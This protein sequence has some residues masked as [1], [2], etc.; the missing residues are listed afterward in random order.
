MVTEMSSLKAARTGLKRVVSGASVFLR[1]RKMSGKESTM[2]KKVVSSLIVII[3][4]A[5]VLA[6]VENAGAKCVYKEYMKKLERN[7]SVPYINGYA[8]KNYKNMVAGGIKYYFWKTNWK[9][10]KKS[11]S[12]E[13]FKYYKITNIGGDKKPELIMSKTKYAQGNGRVLICKYIKGKVRP[14]FCAYGLRLG[15]FKVKKKQIAFGF[16]GSCFTTLVFTKLSGSKLKN[17]TVFTRL[18]VKSQ[19]PYDTAYY[20]G[21]KRISY[22]KFKKKTDTLSAPLEFKPISECRCEEE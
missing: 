8:K 15:L 14:L 9:A 3:M 16:G 19:T 21:Y 4:A 12:L 13:Q 20:H 7:V 1:K 22:K 5:L 2:R 18:K 17:M 6:P 11:I 10:K